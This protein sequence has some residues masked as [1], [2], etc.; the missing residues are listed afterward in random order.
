MET[1]QRPLKEEVT[2]LSPTTKGM[3]AKFG[4]L[5][6][7]G[8]VLQHAWKESSTGEVSRQLVVPRALHKAVLHSVHGAVGSSDFGVTKNLR[9]GFY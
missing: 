7:C 8:D 2:V 5:Q 9:Y 4:A 3:W 6:L 1:Q